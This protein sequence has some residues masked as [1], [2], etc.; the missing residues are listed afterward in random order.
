M[1]ISF[2]SKMGNGFFIK[3]HKFQMGFQF[4]QNRSLPLLNCYKPESKYFVIHNTVKLGFLKL[5]LL[6][7]YQHLK[8]ALLQEV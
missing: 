8:G 2:C 4:C 6:I 3:N 1:L 5:Y 7:D